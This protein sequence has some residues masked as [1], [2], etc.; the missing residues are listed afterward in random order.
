MCVA[1]LAVTVALAAPAEAAVLTWSATL[2][3][4]NEIP[5][6]ATTG[7][8][9]GTVGF[10]DVTNILALDLEWQN[11]TG[12]GVQAHIHCCVA[13]PPGNVGIA[14][15]LWLVANPQP[16]SG[17][18]SAVY[19][20]DADNPFRAAFVTANGGTSLAA[21]QALIAAMNAGDRAYFNIHTVMFP[22]GE[23]RGNLAAVPEPA[24][25]LLLAG[26]IVAVLRRRRAWRH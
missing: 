17:T 4:A 9:F 10:D 23:I 19:D 5:P 21:M 1:A 14:L 18:Y 15:D 6:N 8:G 22:G 13:A 12:D 25:V 3:G 11:L 16:A 7:D 26:G 24:G 20:L 2:G